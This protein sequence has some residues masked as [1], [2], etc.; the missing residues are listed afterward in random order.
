MNVCLQDTPVIL[1]QT[2]D[3]NNNEEKKCMFQT[4]LWGVGTSSVSYKKGLPRGVPPPLVSIHKFNVWLPPPYRVGL[5]QGDVI[6]NSTLFFMVLSGASLLICRAI[7]I[8]SHPWKFRCY[9]L[10]SSCS[11]CQHLDPQFWVWYFSREKNT[12]KNNY[13]WLKFHIQACRNLGNL[14]TFLPHQG[15]IRW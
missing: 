2:P 15:L 5:P 12:N 10:N 3:K 6:A 13:R 11:F 14:G 8:D 4:S 9:D 1:I 7:V